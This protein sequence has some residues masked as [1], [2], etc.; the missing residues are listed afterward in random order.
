VPEFV[1]LQGNLQSSREKRAISEVTN[2]RAKLLLPY[3]FKSHVNEAQPSHL[4]TD[5]K[6][7]EPDLHVRNCDR[8]PQTP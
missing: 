7:S 2:A 4:N 3:S 8:C 6:K 1:N 5:H